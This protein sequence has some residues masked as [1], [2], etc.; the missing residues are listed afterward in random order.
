[1]SAGG[2]MG[3]VLGGAGCRAGAWRARYVGAWEAYLGDFGRVHGW[4]LGGR[5][6]GGAPV[7]GGLT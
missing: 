1:M 4:S 7:S 5:V 3:R 6:R 2:R